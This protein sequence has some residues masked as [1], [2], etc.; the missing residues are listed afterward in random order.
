MA[1]TSK[2]EKKMKKTLTGFIERRKELIEKRDKIQA[3]IDQL[4]GQIEMMAELF[5][6]EK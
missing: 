1:K 5:E 4:D 6:E 2:F 3:G